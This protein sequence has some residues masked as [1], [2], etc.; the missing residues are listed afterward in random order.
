M[1]RM[2]STRPVALSSHLELTE[3]PLLGAQFV[4]RGTAI[5]HPGLETAV[6]FVGGVEIAPLLRG[7]P[8]GQTPMQ[9]ARG[10]TTRVPLETG[11]ALT[12]WMLRHNVLVDAPDATSAGAGGHA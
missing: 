3:L 5:R 9:L 10:W 8:V 1:A 6:A 7:L 2:S 4:E 12:A 11:I